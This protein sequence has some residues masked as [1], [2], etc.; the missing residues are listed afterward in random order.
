MVSITVECYAGSKAEEYPL[1]FQLDGRTHEVKSTEDRWLTPGCRCFKVLTEDGNVYVLQ[2][3]EVL[4][5]WNLLA[6]NR[7]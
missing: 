1:R 4:D 3:E 7:Q 2:Y 6:T 5:T